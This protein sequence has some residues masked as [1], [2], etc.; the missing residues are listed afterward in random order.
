MATIPLE[1]GFCPERWRHTVDIMLEKI[2]G[3]ARTN[4]L[5]IIQLLEVDLNQFL[6]AAYAINATK[7]AKNHDRVTSE[8]QYGRPQRACISPILNKLLTIY[9]LVQKQ[10]NGIIFDNNAK[11]CYDRIISEISLATVRRPGYSKNAVRMIWKLWEQ[12]EH[13]ISTGYGISERTFSGTAENFL[14]G[15]GQGSCSSPILWALLNQL[16]LTALGERFECIT[17]LSVD[18][19]KTST[20]P[21]DSFVDDTTTGVASDNTNREQISIE[22]TELTADE[23]ELVEQIQVGIHNDIHLT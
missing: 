9:I 20:R 16:I 1:T 21:G 5:R 11:G 17:L 8:H 6:R 12:L 4:K 15:I 22:E 13:H 2:P 14:Y 3:I 19:S 23:E 18:N 10:T 7:L